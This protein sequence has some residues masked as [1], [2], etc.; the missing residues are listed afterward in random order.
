MLAIAIT[1]QSPSGLVKALDK[2]AQCS[3]HPDAIVRENFYAGLQDSM[4]MS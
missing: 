1:V 4:V 3:K 2:R